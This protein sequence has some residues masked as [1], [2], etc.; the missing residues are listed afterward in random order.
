MAIANAG[1]T[2]TTI[3]L[4]ADIET[5]SNIVI[6]YHAD[7]TLTSAGD[8]MF[9]IIATRDMTTITVAESGRRATT[10]TV[11]VDGVVTRSGGR[12]FAS[13]TLDNVGV[14]RAR[15][16]VGAGIRNYG[17]LTMN[18][19]RIYG[20]A[21]T[22][23]S[24]VQNMRCF[25]MYG[26]TISDN[27]GSSRGGGVLNGSTFTMH[28]GTISGN[29]ANIGAGVLNGG[30]FTMHGGT[31]TNNATFSNRRGNV[32]DRGSAGGVYN[33]RGTFTIYGGWIFGNTSP[34]YADLRLL[35]RS[36]FIDNLFLNPGGGA[37]GSGPS[38]Q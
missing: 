19:G 23:G 15:A 38:S 14:T 34:E 18:S 32:G 7:I 6:P 16:T 21:G 22:S 29:T 36:V 20:N 27:A 30:T 25:I 31:I 5:A 35:P 2:P 28:G 3:T 24:G 37:I 33:D 10:V 17:Y 4:P 12:Q 1:A 26:G 9:S 11:T 13:L 8:N